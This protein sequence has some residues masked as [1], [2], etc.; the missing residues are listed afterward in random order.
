M[1]ANCLHL[2]GGGL[3]F[4]G[5]LESFLVSDPQKFFG[6]KLNDLKL[7]LGRN[8]PHGFYYFHIFTTNTLNFHDFCFQLAVAIFTKFVAKSKH[9]KSDHQP[10]ILLSL[11]NIFTCVKHNLIADHLVIKS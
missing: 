2:K 8:A 4:L 7:T 5:M 6:S 9:R 3:W 1:H 11:Y 10:V